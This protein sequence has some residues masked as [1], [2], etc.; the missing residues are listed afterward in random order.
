MIEYIIG[1]I[2][3][4]LLYWIFNRDE[5]ECFEIDADDSIKYKIH[6]FK[7]NNI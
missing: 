5:K 4:I 6:R 1:I 2:L 3:T 7:A